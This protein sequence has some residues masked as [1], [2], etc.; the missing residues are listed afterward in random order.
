MPLHT[1]RPEKEE[2]KRWLQGGEKKDVQV[3]ITYDEEQYT[4]FHAGFLL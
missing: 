3:N 1:A 4:V 2:R